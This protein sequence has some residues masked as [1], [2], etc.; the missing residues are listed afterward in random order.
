MIQ[1]STFGSP[2]KHTYSS[3][4][5]VKPK[6]FEWVHD[7]LSSSGIEVYMD[8]N[9]LGG[10]NSKSKNKFLWLCE[11]RGIT[12]EQNNFL[13][14]NYDF[15]KQVYKKIFVH[16]YELLK[17]GDSCIY[18]PP[19]ANM[20]WV[21]DRQIY[22]KSKMVS[23]ISSGKNFCAGHEYRNKKLQEFKNTN[24]PVDYYGR[25]FN[26]FKI[27]EDVLRDYYFSITIENERYSNYYTEKLMDCFATGTIPVYHGTPEVS[28]MFNMDGI[29][30][31]DSD[32]DINTL[33]SDLYFSKMDA[34]KDNFER[35]INHES[36]DDYI[37]NYIKELI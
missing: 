9:V 5:N 12:P 27:K 4:V 7:T 17:L 31:L 35:C 8:Y 34:I 30:I 6:N 29:I 21:V 19:A 36:A 2:F 18:C 16:D 28:T 32:F 20:T 14:H 11:S 13:K 10:L 1:L 24:Y 37:F 25:S 3:C 15:L 22:Y 23:M 33:S 26:P